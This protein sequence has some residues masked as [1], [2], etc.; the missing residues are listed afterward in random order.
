[1]RHDT[2]E[3]LGIRLLLV[4]LPAL[5]LL[6]CHPRPDHGAL[7]RLPS[8]SQPSMNLQ[9]DASTTSASLDLPAENGTSGCNLAV[10]G[11]TDRHAFDLFD[12]RLRSAAKGDDPSAFANLVMYPLRVNRD[13]RTVMIRSPEELANDVEHIFTASVRRDIASQQGFFCRDSGLVYG[14]GTVWVGVVPAARQPERY[15]VSTVNVPEIDATRKPSRTS[16]ELKLKCVA[17]ANTVLVE[18]LGDTLRYRSWRTGQPPTVTPDV[19]LE[20]GT[21]TFEG[22]GVCRQAIYTFKNGDTTYEV[23]ELGCT[24]GSEP[25]DATG[26]LMVSLDGRPVAESLCRGNSN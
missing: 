12:A 3:W 11:G 25:A 23:R 8:D 16:P 10:F 22:T 18:D 4:L 5:V 21:V 9:P 2:E 20:H 13:N 24:D 15:A 1:M 7:A 26:R 14:A 19:V 6:G 17:P